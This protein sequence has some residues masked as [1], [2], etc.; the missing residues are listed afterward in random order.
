M[1]D[2]E[3]ILKANP[4][5]MSSVMLGEAMVK[6]K[7][8]KQLTNYQKNADDYIFSCPECYLV[9]EMIE[10]WKGKERTRVIHYYYDF[11][12]YGRIVKQCENCV[13]I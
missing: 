3:Q 7:E 8:R 2:F 6:I 11:P 9:W 12:K 10:G 1:N 5:I 4:C 13:Y